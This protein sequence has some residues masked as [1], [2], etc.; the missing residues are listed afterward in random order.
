MANSTFVSLKNGEFAPFS[1]KI[2]WIV[3]KKKLS[4]SGKKL[5]Q[6]NLE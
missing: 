6:I 5:P 4:L 2:L 3:A 1:K